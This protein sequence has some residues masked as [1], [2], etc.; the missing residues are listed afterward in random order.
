MAR[1]RVSKFT[2]RDSYKVVQD[3][4]GGLVGGSVSTTDVAIAAELLDFDQ[5]GN[6][7]PIGGKVSAIFYSVYVMVK[8]TS[9]TPLIDM[10]WWKNV[11]N[12]LT[13]IPTPGNTGVSDFKSWIIHE[14]KGL[15]SG[16]EEGGIPMIVKGVLRIPPKMQRFALNDRIQ[17]KLQVTTPGQNGNFCAKHIYKVIY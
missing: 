10:Y 6:E 3:T 11:A 4:E 2:G 8:I 1:G 7:V 5:R 12:N 16:N 15:A 17:F 13:P 14:E 9:G